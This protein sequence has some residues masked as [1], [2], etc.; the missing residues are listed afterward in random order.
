MSKP[1]FTVTGRAERALPPE[2]SI[3]IVSIA[4]DGVD[5]TLVS[6]LAADIHNR[7]VSAATAYRRTNAAT[8]HAASAPS[9]HTYLKHFYGDEAGREPEQRFSAWS[10]ITVKFQDFEVMADWLADLG[11]EESVNVHVSW[12][13]TVATRHA[14]EAEI[15]GKAVA[16]ARVLAEQYA[17][18]DGLS[19]LQLVSVDA[20]GGSRSFD[21][22][23]ATRAAGSAQ[24]VSVIIPNDI[25]VSANVT[26]VFKVTNP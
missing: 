7:L 8:W 18:G 13:L 1:T 22:A 3:V 9:T 5:R 17:A 23:I 20:T 16:N 14:I 26:A 10:T 11:A 12:A 24:P 2:R 4:I 6:R 19:G 25:T 21:G 15:R